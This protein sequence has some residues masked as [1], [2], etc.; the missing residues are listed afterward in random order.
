MLR[1]GIAK[2]LNSA[3]G[4]GT[5]SAA[6]A[7]VMGLSRKEYDL[8][9]KQ[10]D[11]SGLMQ[12]V[13]VHSFQGGARLSTKTAGPTEL[14]GSIGYKARA[15]KDT[16]KQGLQKFGF[17]RGENYN[18]SFTYALALHRKIKSGG[19]GVLKFTQGDWDDL[20][21]EASNLAL[22]MV[23]VNN[24]AYQQGA[25]GVATQF[26][27]FSH[28]AA[29]GLVGANPAIKGKDV[30][31]VLAGTY[32][33]YGANMYG[34]RDFVD[35]RLTAMGLRDQNIPGLEEGTLVDLI[36]AGL[37]D[38]TFNK[39]WDFG[40]ADYK[41]IDLSFLAPGLDLKRV[42][43]DNL[44]ALAQDSAL[45][46]VFGPFGNVFSKTL[47]Q[48]DYVNNVIRGNPDMDDSDKFIH[49]TNALMRGIFP[50]YN[51]AMAA[52][53]GH[54]LGVWLDNKGES[55]Q[56]RATF[57]GLIARG[58]FGGR[59]KEELAMYAIENKIWEDEAQVRE[60]VRANQQWLV[61]LANEFHNG[62]MSA[63]VM[64]QNLRI[65][66]NLYEEWPEA[67]RQEVLERSLIE[68]INDG[69]SPIELFVNATDENHVDPTYEAYI[70]RF[71]DIPPELRNELKIIARDA[72]QGKMEVDKKVL[73]RIE[74]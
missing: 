19:K 7:K 14:T 36:S 59:T 66:A 60:I 12:L 40:S 38:T 22:G 47:Q 55:T 10:L 9:V 33:L 46:T 50:A 1:R 58:L 11:R 62:V 74:E 15:L 64:R 13:D 44:E 71:T 73:E 43:G 37:I 5:T 26:L 61:R 53:T 21:Q 24:F 2:R 18:L 6:A 34:A 17:N 28:K 52:W 35:E 41:D 3:F 67:K 69:P 45:A 8:V 65:L 49:T 72:Y 16:V 25:L 70:D 51:D 31:K 20:A 29:L 68:S 42:V 63:E 23:R 4:D 48:F 30:I 54:Q 56:I 32:F 39:L 27:S 57:N